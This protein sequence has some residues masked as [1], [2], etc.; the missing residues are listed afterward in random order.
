MKKTLLLKTMLLL[1]AL[2]AGSGSVWAADP[3]LT[4]DF[5]SAWTAGEDNSDGE[6]V[7]TKTV[8]TTTYTI[9]GTGGANFKFNTGYFMLGK[10][11]AY[12]KLP[13]VDFDVEKIEVVGNSG[14]SGSVVHNI[15]VGSTAASTAVTGLNG[16]TSS[17]TIGT[18]YQAANTQYILKVTSN[19]NAQITYIKYY[20]KT[21]G[22]GGST[23]YTPTFDPTEG[24]YTSAQSVAL[25]CTT[26]GA[27]IHYTITE[28]G[29]TPDDPTESDATYISTPISVTKSGTKIKAKAFKSGMTAS[30]VASATYTIKPNA[31]TI[32]GGANV[33]ITGDD[34][35]TFYYTTNNSA[36]TDASTE[37]TGAF[38]P[39]DCTIKAVAYDTYGNKSDVVT[40]KYKNMPLAPKNINSGYYEKVTDVSDLENGDAILIVNEGANVAL[41][42]Q[43]GNNCPQKTVKIS[44]GVISNKGDAQKLVLVKKNET[45]NEVATDVFY[46]YTGSAYLYAASNSSNYL[47]TEATPDDNNNARATISITSGDATIQFTGTYSH[48]WLKYNSSS[49]LFSCYATTD[50]TQSIVQIYKEVAHNEPVTISSAEYAT[51]NSECALDFSATGITVYTATDNETYV[52][53]NEVATGKVPANTPVVLYKAG[54]D[55]SAIDVPVIAS[56]DAIAGTNDLHVSTG[57]DVENMYVLAMNPTIG[58]YPWA[59]TTDL[60]AGKIYLQGNASYSAREFIGFDFGFGGETTGINAVNGSRFT[61]NGSQVYNLNGQR[62]ANPKKGLYIVNGKKVAIK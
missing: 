28:D 8:G 54:A 5:T 6:K 29:T 56:A 61:V 10:T 13:K 24:T 15:F 47:K 12:I 52:A 4:L 26:D 40:L 18:S 11:N 20:K 34:G 27:T 30:S 45:I 22:G 35:L 37:Y 55:G 17:F 59:G 42:P 43:S 31:P 16:T 32:T 33:T 62:V 36:P 3:E 58:F 48:K 38:T 25:G 46:L 23:V 39:E 19:H 2:V 14:A 7:F 50:A 21:S 51:F 9:S 41:G 1:C 49:S 53:L 57:K 60:S 44:A